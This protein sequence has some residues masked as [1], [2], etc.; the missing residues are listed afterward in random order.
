MAKDWRG[1]IGAA[2]GTALA[3]VSLETLQKHGYLPMIPMPLK[4]AIAVIL[5]MAASW[6]VQSVC[7]R[8][9]K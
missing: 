5:G 6:A 9:G 1:T 7:G 2:V 4:L 3:M 8:A